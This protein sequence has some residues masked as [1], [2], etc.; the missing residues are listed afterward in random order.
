MDA[1]PGPTNL[2]MQI[3]LLVC[4]IFIN[5]FFAMSEIAVVSLNDSKVKKM[6]EDGHKKAKKIVKLTKNPSSFL[7]TI[8]IG[9]TL[10]GFLASASASQA[11]VDRFGSYLIHLLGTFGTNNAGIIQTVS[12]IVV[13]LIMSYFTLVLGELVPKRLAMKSPEKIAFGVVSILLFVRGITK[14]FVWFLTLST[15]VVLRLFG[16]NPHEEQEEVTEE[17]ILMMV[18]VGE[19]KG[20]IEES[21][22]E[23]INNIFEFDD[24]TAGEVMTHRTDIVAVE[25]TDSLETVANLAMEEGFSRIPVY[26]DDLDNI[27]G[28]IYV[29]DL[30]PFTGKA[31]PADM[32]AADKMRSVYYVPE[33][34]KCGDLFEELTEKRLQLAIVV[35]EYG[36][37][38]GLITMEDLIESILGNIQDEYDDE[39]EDIEQLSETVFTIDGVTDLDEV[40]DELGRILP[41]GD[42]DTLAGMIISH[43]GYIPSEDETP[44]VEVNHILFTVLTVEDRRIEKV[45]VEKLPLPEKDEEEEDDD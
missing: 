14:P 24:I 26:E 29:K 16:I 39:E 6:A 10:A 3:L 19:E 8:Q 25:V 33:S 31:F 4:L 2:W 35:D 41:K 13:T 40:E 30:L 27:V 15:N 42:Y 23:M 38:A 11:F 36:G 28:L 12:L 34:K 5:A 21:Q 43:L 22:K 17:E 1:D 45:R 7:S 44:S 37:T 9:V 18:D 20:V 32:T